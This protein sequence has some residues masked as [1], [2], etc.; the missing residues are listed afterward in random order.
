MEGFHRWTSP[1]LPPL[2]L[3]FSRLSGVLVREQQTGKPTIPRFG[4]LTANPSTKIHQHASFWQ[5]HSSKKTHFPTCLLARLAGSSAGD[6][7]RS[8]AHR[9]ERRKLVWCAPTYRRARRDL[10]YPAH[11]RPHRRP[12][13][14]TQ[15]SWKAPN[16]ESQTKTKITATAPK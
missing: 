13:L 10:N 5:Q 12:L 16:W 2:S 11:T 7:L 3:L 8:A 4:W 1:W 6:I 15:Q 14:T 9:D